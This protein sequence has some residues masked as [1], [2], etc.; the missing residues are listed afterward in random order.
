MLKL[1]Q[2]IMKKSVFLIISLFLITGISC[3]K[4]ESMTLSEFCIGTWQYGA[5]DADYKPITYSI[6]FTTSAKYIFSYTDG[7]NTLTFGEK[8][9]TVDDEDNEITL[10]EI[11]I[12][13]D[14]IWKSGSNSMQWTEDGNPQ[15]PTIIIWARK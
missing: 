11:D 9:Y 13:Y 1:K 10:D 5:L 14:V 15:N 12:T 4:E 3:Q 8:S 6:E 2:I 7:N